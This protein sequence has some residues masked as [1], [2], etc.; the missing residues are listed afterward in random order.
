MSKL[1]LLLVN[2]QLSQDHLLKHYSLPLN[3]LCTPHNNQLT[4]EIWFCFLHLHSILV[5][6]YI[7]SL[8][9]YH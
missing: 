6:V 4:T 1:I 5:S 2:I 8:C 3:G 7:Q 9:H